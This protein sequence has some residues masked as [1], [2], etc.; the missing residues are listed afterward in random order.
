MIEDIK[1]NGRGQHMLR[2]GNLSNHRL[3]QKN[4]K[5]ERLEDFCAEHSVG[6]NDIGPNK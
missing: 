6:K 5:G 1:A 4:D 2:K 3:R